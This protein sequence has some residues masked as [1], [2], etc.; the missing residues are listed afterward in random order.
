MAAF[1]PANLV[2]ETSST[3][4][5]GTWTLAGAVTGFRAWSNVGDGN[6]AYYTATDAS[7]NW[8]IGI[9]TYTL[10]GTTLARTTILASSN[11][12]SAVNFT[13]TVTIACVDVIEAKVQGLYLSAAYTLTS[14][15]AAQKLFNSSTNGAI[16]LQPGTYRFRVRAFIT[17]MAAGS[18]TFGFALGGT[19]T[20]TQSWD[21]MANK[22]VAAAAVGTPTINYGNTAANA[23][24]VTAVAVTTGWFSI[25]GIIR[26]TV[27]GTVIPQVSLSVA[28]A[29]IVGDK[30]FC[31]FERV[32]SATETVVGP[33]WS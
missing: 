22:A 31:E 2:K 9:G 32:G 17:G 10:S 12:G 13:T 25:E 7:G 14:Q 5:T 15:T 26:V 29:A 11:A 3:A 24:L 30:S 28:A 21:A 27:A 20:F 6:T 19:A 23:A 33:N 1:S 18:N 8:E 16:T 4:G